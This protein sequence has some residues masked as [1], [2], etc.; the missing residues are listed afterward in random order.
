MLELKIE[1]LQLVPLF[2]GLSP[3]ELDAIAIAG[4]KRFFETGENLIRR[5]RKA[6]PPS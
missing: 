5:A 2:T 6:T 1:L 3:E 4:E